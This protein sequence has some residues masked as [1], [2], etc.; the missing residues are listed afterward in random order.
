[1]H[2][3]TPYFPHTQQIPHNIVPN[4]IV[5]Q[6]HPVNTLP[7][8]ITHTPYTHHI[9]TQATNQQNTNAIDPITKLSEILTKTLTTREHKRSLSSIQI[10]SLPRLLNCQ[11]EIS[12][13]NFEIWRRTILK[14]FYA[15]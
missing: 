7:Q 12:I 8:T 2:Y 1:M 10:K 14:V 15:L 9:T 11:N 3:T 13:A 4:N 6:T 5:P